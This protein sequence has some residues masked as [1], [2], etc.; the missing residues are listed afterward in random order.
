MK[1]CA[2][3]HWACMG[4]IDGK[5]S[6]Q[7]LCLIESLHKLQ[8]LCEVST[9]L[10]TLFLARTFARTYAFSNNIVHQCLTFYYF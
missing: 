3:L 6:I 10:S 1:I 8:I 2:G 4:Q 9:S 7:V 5:G